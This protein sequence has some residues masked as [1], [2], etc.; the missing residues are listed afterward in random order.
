MAKER[1]EATAEKV[2]KVALSVNDGIRFGFGFF[3]VNLLGFAAIGLV[4]W[5][6]ILV[7]RYFGL[8]F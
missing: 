6:I 1:V 5:A 3:L 4:A 7:A 2:D 8:I